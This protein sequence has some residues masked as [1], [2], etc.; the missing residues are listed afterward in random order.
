MSKL[1]APAPN[2]AKGGKG[3]GAKAGFLYALSAYGLWGF[4]PLYFWVMD[5]VPVLQ[6]LAHRVVWSL[7]VALAVLAATGRL[8]E[9]WALRKE[10]RLL[11]MMALTATFISINWGVYILSVEMNLTSQAA[12]GYYINPL[13]SVLMGVVLLS[14]R[15]DR[16]QKAAIALA[17][18]G[19]VVKTIAGGTF[20]LIALTLAFS[21]AFY[22]YLRKTVAIGPTA[23]FTV[24]VALLFPLALGYLIWVE[25]Q[26]TGAFT[27]SL[28]TAGWLAFAGPVTA[29]PLILYAYSAKRLRLATLGLMQYIAPSMIFLLAFTLFG[30]PLDAAQIVT[31][32]LIW[33]ALVLYTISVMR[34]V[35]Q[36]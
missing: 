14:E 13:I 34:P 19:V 24:E 3:D 10:P 7:P 5:G 26:G 16:L 9:L 15:L 32:A 6:L 35:K 17:F 23:G 4:L 8:P 18:V 30:E 31:F 21:F 25:V 20:P 1:A 29:T 2:P 28:E 36:G 33:S 22:G 12:L 11:A 27:Q